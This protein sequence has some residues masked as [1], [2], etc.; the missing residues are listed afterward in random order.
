[1]ALKIVDL[2][3]QVRE[4]RDCVDWLRSIGAI[5][6]G[7]RFGGYL[8][9]LG[10]LEVRCGAGD[11]PRA[12]ELMN[13]RASVYSMFEVVELISTC[14][15]LRKIDDPELHRRLAEFASGPS[16][17]AL[18]NPAVSSNHS[19]NIGFELSVAGRLSSAGIRPYFDGGGDVRF[20]LQGRDIFVECKRPQSG[21]KVETAVRKARQKLVE[22]YDRADKP[23]DARGIVALNATKVLLPKLPINVFPTRDSCEMVSAALATDFVETFKRLWVPTGGDYPLKDRRTIGVLVEVRCLVLVRDGL[24]VVGGTFS[25]DNRPARTEADADLVLALAKRFDSDSEYV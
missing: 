8:R 10:D 12:L 15:A 20:A 22:R 25:L 18:E 3:E 2:G 6:D 24:P 4:L 21:Q 17:Y 16:D 19:R 9:V 11:Y 7:A 13:D 5:V 14:R 23:Q 1:M